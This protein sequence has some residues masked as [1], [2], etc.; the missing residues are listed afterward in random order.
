MTKTQRVFRLMHMLTDHHREKISAADLAASLNV[1]IRTIYADL[2]YLVQEGVPVLYDK[3]CGYR[4]PL[5]TI[6]Q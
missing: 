6:E 5:R 3:Q 2:A 4:I 1:T